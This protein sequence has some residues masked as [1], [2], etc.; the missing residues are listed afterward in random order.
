LNTGLSWRLTAG[1]VARPGKAP[2]QRY[3]IAKNNGDYLLDTHGVSQF[4]VLRVHPEVG[5]LYG[6]TREI[7]F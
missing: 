1:D 4:V 6:I 5:T 2:K 7:Y 3:K